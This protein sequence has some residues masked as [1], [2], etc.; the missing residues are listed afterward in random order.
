MRWAVT[1]ASGYLDDGMKVLKTVESAIEATSDIEFDAG[2]SYKEKIEERNEYRANGM[3][4]PNQVPTMITQLDAIMAGGLGEGELGCVVATPNRGKSI[5]LINFAINAAMNN[6]K[7]VYFTLGDMSANQ[8]G[9][10]MDGRLCEYNKYEMKNQLDK[11][12][13]KVSNLGTDLYIKFFPQG[14]ATIDDL[15]LYLITLEKM[16]KFKPDLVIVDM[17]EYI[18]ASSKTELERFRLKAI[19]VELHGLAG[20]M[21]L[22]IWTAHQANIFNNEKDEVETITGK[23][24][25]EAKVGIIGVCDFIMS[26]NQTKAEVQCKPNEK[27]RLYI[28]RQRDGTV[29]QT[30]GV[31][32]NKAKFTVKDST[33]IYTNPK[34]AKEQVLPDGF[35]KK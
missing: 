17:A 27:M 1:T 35:N 20:E 32:I 25:A 9:S 4:V 2:Y 11:V 24:L 7:V 3:R 34:L 23:H 10:R 29:E 6:K 12:N 26:A 19:F 13:Y 14:Y 8:V 5:L 21:K 18:K 15:K 31:T 28:I 16:K 22:P 33:E 30:I